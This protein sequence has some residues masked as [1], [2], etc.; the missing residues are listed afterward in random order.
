MAVGESPGEVWRLTDVS[1]NLGWRKRNQRKL[2][3]LVP[4]FKSYIL[5]GLWTLEDFQ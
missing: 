4:Y 5:T 2:D 1:G 3:G